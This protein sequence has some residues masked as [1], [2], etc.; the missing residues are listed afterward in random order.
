MLFIFM[1]ELKNKLLKK[2]KINFM[3]ICRGMVYTLFKSSSCQ[4]HWGFPLCNNQPTVL[5]IPERV[6]FKNFS[7]PPAM[8]ADNTFQRSMAPPLWNQ[9]RGH[10]LIV[11]VDLKL[12]FNQLTGQCWFFG[13]LS[14]WLFS[15]SNSLFLLCWTYPS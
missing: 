3:V 5:A 13:I 14:S 9:F 11:K 2:I 7:C 8:D 6:K 15:C 4:V 12:Y 1:E 10:C